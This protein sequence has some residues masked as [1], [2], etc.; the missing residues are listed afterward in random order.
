MATAQALDADVVPL[1]AAWRVRADRGVQWLLEHRKPGQPWRGRRSHV[2]RD[3]L[4]RSIR[5]VCGEVDEAAVA[6]IAGFTRFY[7]RPE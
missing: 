2:D 5:E 1:N 7:G 6:I 3:S 4:L